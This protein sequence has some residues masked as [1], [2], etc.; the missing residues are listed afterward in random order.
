LALGLPLRNPE[1]LRRLLEQLY[2]PASS[3]YRQY[4]TTDQFTAQFGPSEQ[5]YQAVVAFAT[6]HG[7]SVTATHPNRMILDVSG[8]VSTIEQALHITLRLYQH[9]TET[10]T[11]YAPDTEPLLEPAVPIL[12]ISGLDNY[13]L[14]RPCMTVRPI[15]P[16]TNH[17]PLTGTAPQGNYWGKDFRTA[18]APG[19]AMDGSGQMVGLFELDGYYPTDV[20]TYQSQARLPNVPLI[21]VVLDGFN[22]SPGQGNSEVALD[23][24]LASAMAP[25]LSAIIVYEGLVPNDVLNRMAT[26]NLAKQL[27]ASWTFPAD[28]V[29]TQIFQQFAAQGQSY[30]NASGDSGAYGN[31]PVSPADNPY[32]TSV[33]GTL[34]HTSTSGGW[35]VETAWRSSASVSS[36]GG[37]SAG[38]AIP[39]YQQTIDMT[40][41][42]G[43]TSRRNSPD[44]AMIAD[45]VWI[46]FDNGTA[47][48]AGGTSCASPLWASF[49]AMVNQQAASVG[50]PSVGFLNPTL[51][52]IGQGPGYTTNFHDMTFGN[53]TNAI[54][55]TLFS[56]VPGYDLCTGWGSP[57]GQNLI[58]TLAPRPNAVIVTNVGATLVAEGCLPAN[59]AIDPGETVTVSVALR[60]L[61]ALATTNL[62]AVLQA[63]AG[64]IA[65]SVPQTY[66]VLAGGGAPVSRNFSFTAN[67]LCGSTLTTT[68]HLFDAAADLGELQFNFTLGRSAAVFAENFDGVVVPA[69]PAGWSNSIS[70]SVSKWGT[71]VLARD[72]TPYS[73]FVSDS[74]NRG[75]TELIS[76]PI[77]LTSPSARLAFRQNYNLECHFDSTNAYDGSVLEIQIAGGPFQDI[78][79][80][81]GSF[82][83]GGY[84]K[85]VQSDPTDLSP[86]NGRQVWSGVSGGFI[87]TIVNLPAAAAYETIHLKWRLGTDAEN[88]GGGFGWNI[89]SV[90][91][92]EGFSCCNPIAD[93]AVS[94]SVSS[95][96]A[97]IQQPVTYTV[98]LVNA[99]PQNAYGALLTD[100]LPSNVTFSS[101]SGGGV[102][103]N[104]TVTWDLGTLTG[105]SSAAFS[106]TVLPVT[107]DALSNFLPVAAITA[108]PNPANDSR[109]LTTTV[110]TSGIPASVSGDPVDT[111]AALGAT[112]SF[113][114]TAGGIPSPTFQWV[115]NGTNLLP[116]TAAT[117]SLTNVQASAAGAYQAVVTNLFGSATSAVARLIVLAPPAVPLAG[118]RLTSTNFSLSL[119][120]L[121][122]LMYRLEFKNS[123][124]DPIWTAVSPAL[125]GTGGILVLPDTNSPA[126]TSRFYRVACISSPL[127]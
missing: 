40:T 58:N 68:L 30:F 73:A 13:M 31:R 96:P 78:L 65:P 22:G 79:D 12:H 82:V 80:A 122:G 64:V 34:L 7:L 86:F 72:T 14:A 56:A 102:Y 76:P 57:I 2:D 19:V 23:I 36:G 55:P 52:A 97:L 100:V 3:Q 98:N 111:V 106:V 44:V 126:L 75:I 4:L 35:T 26:D 94:Q 48:A 10:R 123:L 124:N 27:S 51:Y 107:D 87:T 127:P 109:S 83:S 28:P 103:T 63:D 104:G 39:A 16:G 62:V 60:N 121:S 67:G 84:N 5:D 25:G 66:G 117:L 32:V 11:F 119:T 54:S 46:I 6:Q 50:L 71:T 85:T 105:G 61:G 45:F 59:G 53:N 89:D 43:S 47:A 113:Q 112:A 93:L 114:V 42:Q 24:E 90:A 49:T 118:L 21:N 125:P 15:N 91:V 17:V 33:G 18:Y 88:A 74:T 29:T 37:V 120:G 99:G 38:Y 20:R 8:T 77:T 70:G 1:A 92:Q 101:A 41:N 116:G 108:D 9:P 69:L 115:F 81:G 95:S 110:V